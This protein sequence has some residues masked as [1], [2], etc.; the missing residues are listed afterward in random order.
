[1]WAASNLAENSDTLQPAVLVIAHQEA[2]NARRYM[3]ILVVEEEAKVAH[4]LKEGL[5]GEHYEVIV[6]TTGEDGFFRANAEVFD[7]IVLDVMLPGRDG[8]EILAT[9]RKR[10]MQ[11]PVLILT[12][13]DAVED[14]VC[15]LDS[16]ADDYLVKPFAFP[17]LLARIRAPVRRGRLDQMRTPTVTSSAACRK[18]QTGW[19]AWWTAYL[20]CPVPMPAN[21]GS[22]GSVWTSPSSRVR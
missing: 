19:D 11:T 7:L 1:M 6:A 22:T 16:G 4:A 21:S 13:K 2:E 9:L 5:E 17:E 18:R 20:P 12:A 10:G 15:G 8:I 14:R 3:R